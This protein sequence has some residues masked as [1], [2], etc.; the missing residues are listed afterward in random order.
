[1]VLIHF[2][3]RKRQAEDHQEGPQVKNLEAADVVEEQSKFYNIE[4]M[5]SKSFKGGYICFALHCIYPLATG[6]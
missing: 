1:M 6:K 3:G 4:S 5:G 2:S